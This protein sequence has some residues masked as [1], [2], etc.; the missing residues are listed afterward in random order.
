MYVTDVS[1]YHTAGIKEHVLKHTKF[2]VQ[3][4]IALLARCH[5][6]PLIR[7]KPLGALT[8]VKRVYHSIVILMF[9]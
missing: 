7:D 4:H 6:P 5:N 2:Y 9:V 3:K 8:S 1:K